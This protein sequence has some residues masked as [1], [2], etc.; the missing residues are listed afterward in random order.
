MTA[1]DTSVV[2]PALLGWHEHHDMCRRAAAGATIPAHAL[3]ET[4]SVLT[5]LPA[6]HRIESRAAADLLRRWFPM[7]R[8]LAASVALQHAV[9]SELDGAGVS[10]GA[11]YDALI[12]L[13]A[14]QH[15][16]DL[17]TRDVRASRTYRRVGA[18]H[19]LIEP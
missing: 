14:R 4:Y 18:Q 13:T 15:D 5:R 8:I 1:V 3:I 17:L 7:E 9:L 19:R 2:V 16:E 11:T 12:A 6:P 10:G